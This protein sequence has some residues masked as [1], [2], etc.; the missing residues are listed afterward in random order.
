M[1]LTTGTLIDIYV[2]NEPAAD[3][4]AAATPRTTLLAQLR[5]AIVVMAMA[6]LS[7]A[8]ATAYHAQRAAYAAQAIRD[9]ATAAGL[10][11]RPILVNNGN[12]LW[13]YVEQGSAL[14]DSDVQNNVSATW[15]AVAGVVT[16]EV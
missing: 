14:A 13:A 4:P 8:P 11:L 15:N 9:P 16:V 2:T 6:V 5:T 12:A 1:P 3:V 10:F 7:E